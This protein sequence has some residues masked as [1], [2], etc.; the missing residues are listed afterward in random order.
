MHVEPRS[1]TGSGV[2][3]PP[4]ERRRRLLTE[5][6]VVGPLTLVAFGLRLGAIGQSLFGDEVFA[7]RETG[8]GLSEV[9]DRLGEG[10]AEVSPPL[11]FVLA[12]AARQCGDPTIWIR[13]PSL[14]FGTATVPVVYALGRRIF[15]PPAGVV[16]AAVLAVSPFMIFYSSEARPYA[17]M[18]FFVA[19]ST[20]C[21]LYVVKGAG[22]GWWLG[23]AVS[24]CAAIYTHYTAV[25]VLAAQAGWAFWAYRER[26]RALTLAHLG[27][28][29]GYLPCIL[30]LLGQTR[31]TEEIATLGSFR[32]STATYFEYQGR[33]LFG[34]PFAKPG[35]IPGK[36]GL[37]LLGIA[38]AMAVTTVVLRLLR[39][40]R[41]PPVRARSPAVLVVVLALAT[42]LGLVAFGAVGSSLYNPR[43]LSASIPALAVAA[44]AII[45]S[46]RARF[47][48]PT[49]MLILVALA[50]GTAKILTDY[51]RPPL[52]QVAHDI[53]LEAAPGDAIL[54]YLGGIPYPPLETYFDRPHKV[55]SSHTSEQAA[56]RRAADGRS[57]FV[58][59]AR[60]SGLFRGTPALDGPKN[61]FVQRKAKEYAGVFPVLVGRYA[62]KFR[63]N[64]QRRNG[65]EVIRWSLGQDLSVSRRAARGSIDKMS[66]S[67]NQIT[68]EGWA[69]D[70]AGDA[71]ADFILAFSG[72]RLLA[73][74]RP[75][76]LRPDV[77]EAYGK[78]VIVAGFAVNAATTPR[79]G[80]ATPSKPRVFAVV[81]NRAQRLSPSGER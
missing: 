58:V 51:Q 30:L 5:L 31:K 65:H 37:A 78:E 53:D 11:F 76:I 72:A 22:L 45:T 47:A 9:F 24:A 1:V 46:Y 4:F 16:A 17:T 34:H 35:T 66:V 25:F 54:T 27:I 81:G 63:A 43:N 28:V 12:W 77:A 57:V 20:L 2:R 39:T 62:G 26:V 73:V 21:L 64:L 7:F 23:Y 71:A 68:I 69:T 14:L 59:T 10:G 13:L 48:V 36:T 33:A 61:Q 3:H 52:R 41:R 49:A 8:D 55:F 67:G 80:V 40:G 19:L 79:T 75:T 32:L 70:A 38:A 29:V 56:W 50:I 74:A 44:G 42:P 15:G 18:V 6:L 60:G